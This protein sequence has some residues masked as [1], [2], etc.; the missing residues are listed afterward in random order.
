[1]SIGRE[2]AQAKED[3]IHVYGV[4]PTHVLIPPELEHAFA[5][6]T[7]DMLA[8]I[9]Y[10]E[11]RKECSIMGMK[12]MYADNITRIRVALVNDKP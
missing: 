9:R 2:I 1:M 10:K 4:T 7:N 6:Y 5:E 11:T 3:F 12:V 8:G